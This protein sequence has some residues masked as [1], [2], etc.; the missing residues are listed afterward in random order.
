MKNLPQMREIS[1]LSF[2]ERVLQ[3]AED[4]RNPLLER[5]RFLGIFSS[6]MDEFFKVRVASIHRRLE[7]KERGMKTLLE[8]INDSARQLDERFRQAYADITGQLA[9]QGIRIINE[10]ELLTLPES[11]IAHVDRYFREQ[12]LPALVPLV[13]E[14]TRTFP[15][16]VDGALYMG[17]KMVDTETRYAILEVPQEVPRFVRLPGGLI[18]YL[19]DLIRHSLNEIFYIFHFKTISAWAFKISRDAE[20]DIDNDFS[21]G[22]I[23]KMEKVLKQRKGGRPT[24]FV[25]DAA[26]PD[27]LRK[28]LMK[29]LR[30]TS[31][32]VLLPGGRYHNMRD[33]MCF[34][35]D[36]DELLFPPV[37]PAPHP[38]L[39]RARRPMM[40]IIRE[41]D[42]LVTYPYQ[43][44]DHVLRLLREAAIDP[45]VTAIKITLYRVARNSQVVNALYNAARNGKQI[46]AN[47]ELL[48]R[49][50][51]EN[52]IAA[53][54]R[55]IE[56]GAKV[57][58]GVPPVKVHSK[59]M[60]IERRG[61]RFA[62]LSTGNLNE[63]TA[64]V[65]VDSM[66]LTSDKRITQEV[67]E[68]F[69]YLEHSNLPRTAPPRFKHLLV[70]PFNSRK[71]WLA[72]IEREAAKGAEGYI[73]IKVNHLTDKKVIQ[74]LMEAADAGVK[75]DLI[76]RTTYAMLPHPNIC[77]ISILDRYLEHQRVYIFG[78]G[79][80]RVIY[81][82]SADLME[83]NL[84]WRVEVAFPIYHPELRQQLE[85]TMAMQ[86]ADTCKARIL[87]ER[88]SNAYVPASDTGVHS[89]EETQRYFDGLWKGSIPAH[90]EPL[91]RRLGQ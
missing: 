22:Y 29:E 34:P 3:E 57:I 73:F 68:V 74:R 55:L 15:N 72:L 7:M 64:R 61:E 42:V 48:A 58:Y 82:S 23:R 86:V 52:N 4:T 87:D 2:N 56:V 50:D 85:L 83:R 25:Y 66:L 59:L 44:F 88:Q 36:R 33:L 31:T 70:S 40:D 45:E 12:V 81:L 84:D 9:G 60:L 49:F 5:L 75:M 69:N 77:A 54:N 20:L 26:M 21:D 80:D 79:E 32:D 24:R 89:Q 14:K 27:G 90:L 65:Y 17:V 1:V 76:V 6:N 78:R 41:Q 63:K 91:S 51:E 16:L 28:L 13:L 35:C 67:D 18:M 19:D 10:E 53:S 39:D 8:E 46:T 62:G 11:T 71:R 47:I 38:L 43:S 37:L 30:I